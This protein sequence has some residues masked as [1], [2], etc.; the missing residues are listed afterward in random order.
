MPF[1][2]FKTTKTTNKMKKILLTSL[3]LGLSIIYAQAQ[4]G[5]NAKKTEKTT[6]EKVADFKSKSPADKATMV[7]NKMAE[8]CTLSTEQK[9]KMYQANLTRFTKLKAVRDKYPTVTAENKEAI[10]AEAKPIQQEFRGQLNSVLNEEQKQKWAAYRQQKK[11][12]FKKEKE[13]N[14][15]AVPTEEQKLFEEMIDE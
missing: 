10:K 8:V 3:A 6:N 12:E 9:D 4:P 15:N 1:V 14:P 7:T 5:Q 13:K 2:K 11:E